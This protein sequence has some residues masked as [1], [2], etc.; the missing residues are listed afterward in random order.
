MTERRRFSDREKAAIYAAAGALIYDSI[1]S[2]STATSTAFDARGG[3]VYTPDAL[4]VQDSTI[5]GNSVTA[6]GRGVGG[7]IQV[8]SYYGT[9]GGQAS[10]KYS[11]LSG[12]QSSLWGG[13]AY[14]SGDASFTN[15]TASGNG[16]CSGGGLYFFAGTTPNTVSMYSSTI[17]GNT[18]TCT[19]DGGGVQVD[20]EDLT[21][22]D[23][24]IAF[25][26]AL[27]GNATKYGAG[28]HGFRVSNF[29][30]ENT[31]VAT[32]MT[33]LNG[34][35]LEPD[36]IGGDST[37]TVTGAQNLVYFPDLV[38]P[39]GT[40]LLTDPMLRAL[41]SNGGPTATHMPNFGSPVID[42]GNNVS[43]ATVDQRGTGY[44]RIIGPFPD[45]G[46]VEFTL[47]DEIFADGFD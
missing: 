24:T 32:N 41:A 6:S 8:G 31:I 7:G 17:S 34:T 1:V 18:A 5:T 10:V 12:N 47:V 2:G 20:G 28:L 11:T 39:G 37:T 36:D 27:N 46:S 26:N 43:G 35:D 21:V 14:F 40:I 44:A 33:Q 15:S 45:I 30:L 29:D 16:S 3:G 25:N 23:S 9:N 22:M 19:G 4:I 13:G 38:M 42:A